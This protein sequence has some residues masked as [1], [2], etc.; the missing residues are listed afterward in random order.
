MAFG[1]L[2]IKAPYWVNARRTCP[3]PFVISGQT[4][5]EASRAS[6]SFYV[7]GPDLAT[8][9]GL[10]T[11]TASAQKKSGWPLGPIPDQH[12]PW[13]NS[14]A[15]LGLDTQR[16]DELETATQ[17]GIGPFTCLPLGNFD[18]QIDINDG[19]LPSR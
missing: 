12:P 6:I 8:G 15:H 7:A 10:P 14:D 9:P 4:E 2:T 18:D 11:S 3:H 13:E 1:G 17:V 19:W 5:L 16:P